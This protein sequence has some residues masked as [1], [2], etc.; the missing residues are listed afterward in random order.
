[1]DLAMFITD[2]CLSVTPSRMPGLTDRVHFEDEVLLRKTNLEAIQEDS[3]ESYKQRVEEILNPNSTYLTELQGPDELGE[4][5]GFEPEDADF[6]VP[7]V[8]E[9]DYIDGLDDPMLDKIKGEIAKDLRRQES[10]SS[11]TSSRTEDSRDQE[12]ELN[13]HYSEHFTSVPYG[14]LPRATY[15]HGRKNADIM[16][17]RWKFNVNWIIFQVQLN[18]GFSLKLFFHRLFMMSSCMI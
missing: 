6:I 15:S 9:A 14:V 4:D 7:S 11:E 2:V 8:S 17:S 10:E 12:A 13:I 16:G 1:M 18:L 5:F 3:N